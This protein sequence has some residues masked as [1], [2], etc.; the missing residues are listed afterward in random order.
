MEL[1]SDA[2]DRVLMLSK[3]PSNEE[4]LALYGLFK[5]A[6]V[7]DVKTDCPSIFNMAGRVKWIAWNEQKGKTEEQAKA[8]YIALVDSLVLKIGI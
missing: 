3:E 4:K 1:F 8:D 7:G 2:V 5:Q 6:T